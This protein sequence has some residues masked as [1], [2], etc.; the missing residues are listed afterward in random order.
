MER[1]VLRWLSL[2]LFFASN[3][4]QV[5]HGE[6]WEI[7]RRNNER[8][9]AV[10]HDWRCETFWGS[11]RDFLWFVFTCLRWLEVSVPFVSTSNQ[12]C[13]WCALWPHSARTPTVLR[14]NGT[15][16]LACESHDILSMSKTT[17]CTLTTLP[18]LSRHFWSRFSFSVLCHRST[19]IARL[20]LRNRYFDDP[21]LNENERM[22][23]WKGPLLA[24]G[25]GY[26]GCSKVGEVSQGYT[27]R[28]LH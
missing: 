21:N 28:K 14:H 20:A 22:W 24:N 18:S 12:S 19:K 17:V 3:T 2:L 11:V 1:L 23:K 27:N 9:S 7:S 8:Q 15:I 16:I 4:C 10:Q 25:S 5:Q 26:L 6:C 13:T